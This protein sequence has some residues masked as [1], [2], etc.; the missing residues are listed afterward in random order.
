MAELKILL[1]DAVVGTVDG[2]TLTTTNKLLRGVWKD[3][4]DVSM[5]G[6]DAD[7]NSREIVQVKPGDEGWLLAYAEGLGRYGFD[8][9]KAWWDAAW[10]EQERL[11]AAA[12]VE[13]PD[14]EEV[15]D[16]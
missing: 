10:T 2:V 13:L 3:G 15:A 16:Q 4:V 9:D 14:P 7:S 11:D 12:G 1:D 8:V 5:P 6:G